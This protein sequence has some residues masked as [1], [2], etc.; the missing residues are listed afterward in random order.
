MV[1]L[2]LLGVI[3]D[4]IHSQRFS[5]NGLPF[6]LPTVVT[7]SNTWPIA[8]HQQIDLLELDN[9]RYVIGWTS[10]TAVDGDSYTALAQVF[11]VDGTPEGAEIILNQY[12]SNKQ[13]NVRLVSTPSENHGDFMAVWQSDG[14]DQDDWAVMARHYNRFGQPLADEFRVYGQWQ[15]A[16]YQPDV[17]LLA[18]GQIAVALS[19]NDGSLDTVEL[20]ML[21]PGTNSDDTLQGDDQ[22]NILI[23]NGGNNIIFGE[24]GDD[25]IY[26]GTLA[27]GGDGNDTF[28][29]GNVIL[30]D[31]GDD[32]IYI[33]SGNSNINGGDDF[34]VAFFN[35]NFARLHHHRQP[36]R[37]LYHC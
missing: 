27:Y 14:A 11:A 12:S 5:H 9:G 35:G 10:T 34:D 25:L 13:Q 30:G 17:A 22:P 26:D 24:A 36:Y 29:G 19:N 37:Q 32:N 18:G 33:S 21:S 2:W 15:H 16:Q 4:E 23:G 7:T 8:E 1:A 31:N 28:Y 6:G 20:V 3:D